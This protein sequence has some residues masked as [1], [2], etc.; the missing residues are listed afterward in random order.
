MALWIIPLAVLLVVVVAYFATNRAATHR[1]ADK[2]GGETERALSDEQEPIPS[3]HLITDAERPLGDTPEPHRT[4][5]LVLFALVTVAAILVM[6]LPLEGVMRSRWC[7][8]FFLSWSA[9]IIALAIS[10]AAIDGGAGSPMIML[11][12]L[13]LV[14]AALSYPLGSMIGVGAVTTLAYLALAVVSG[15]APA[16][17]VFL[18]ACA[19]ATATW[20]C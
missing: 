6:I 12:Y 10:L 13:P 11:L 9:G 19:L 18:F 3:T 4:A 16:A 8:V 17:D 2:H 1:V 14:Y 7:E 15:G 5:M 20:I